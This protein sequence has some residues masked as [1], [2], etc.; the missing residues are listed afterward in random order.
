MVAPALVLHG[1]LSGPQPLRNRP[2][3]LARGSIQVVGLL[4][5]DQ[6]S[7]AAPSSSTL[8][9]VSHP[10]SEAAAFVAATPSSAASLD[11]TVRAAGRQDPSWVC[12]A[13][14]TGG[15]DSGII[16]SGGAGAGGG[17]GYGGSSWES[18][19]DE[20]GEGDDAL[21]NLQQAKELA[22]AKGLSLPED[23]ITAAAGTGLRRGVLQA[24]LAL[25]GGNFVTGWLVRTLPAFRDRLIADRLFFFK[26]LAE[27]AIDSGCATVAELRKR[28]DDFWAEFEFYLSDLVVGLVLDVVLVS[29]IAPVA[30][31]GK[32][33]KAAAATGIRKWLG[34]LPSQVFEKSGVRK[35]SAVDRVACYFVK[36]LEYSLAGLFCG[37]AGQGVANGIMHLRR[38]HGGASE[39]DVPIPPLF[40]TAL[41]WGLFMGVSSN[42]RYQVVA[43]LE[44][45]VDMTIARNIPQVA[46]GTTLA[47]RF[48]NNV[49]GGEN[50]IDMARWAGIQ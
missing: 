23:F 41:V 19:S 3:R 15:G 6:V 22:A 13:A 32:A 28:G 44:R 40:R 7:K 2:Q 42:T 17:S 16:G 30:V 25:A 49:I 35:Y 46:Y 11:P 38:Q 27:V 9:G 1:A 21:L 48:V 37:L 43:G 24:Y 47:I 34:Q 20:G 33:P 29:L 5:G 12:T 14:A 18:S 39:H 50:F 8:A 31:I 45:I 10:S 36:G 26:I 4:R